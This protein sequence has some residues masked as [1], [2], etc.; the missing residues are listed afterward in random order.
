M[1][2]IKLVE[3][4]I[5]VEGKQ[6]KLTSKDV[7]TSAL[8][9]YKDGLKG[10][11]NLSLALGIYGKIRDATGEVVLEET[12]YEMLYAAIDQCQFSSIILRFEEFFGTLPR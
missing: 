3:K 9:S 7:L 2:K 5:S 10:V 8:E 6:V 11:K 4:E 1:K 12:E